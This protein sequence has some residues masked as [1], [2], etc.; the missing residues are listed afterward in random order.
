MQFLRGGSDLG[1]LQ[2][3]HDDGG[4]HVERERGGGTALA[5]CLIGDR[6]VEEAGA[7]AAPFLADREFEKAFRSEPVVVLDGM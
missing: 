4:M 7:A 1:A 3:G 5:Q 6:V 2:H